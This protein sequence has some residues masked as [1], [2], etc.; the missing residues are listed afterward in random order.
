MV[1]G[2][3]GFSFTLSE[4]NSHSALAGVAPLVGALS[5]GPK[6]REF[7]SLSGHIH[8]FQV[9]SPVRVCT[10]RKPTDVS[11]PLSLFSLLPPL[12]LS[13][14]NEKMV[15]INIP[16]VEIN[17]CFYLIKESHSTNN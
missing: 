16:Q 6:G 10:R 4:G 15:E 17:I 3:S 12:P 5:H 2:S 7:D 13:R 1:S 9:Q 8:G 14:S 11:L